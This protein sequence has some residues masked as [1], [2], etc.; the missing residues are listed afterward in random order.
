MYVSF[1]LILYIMYMYIIYMEFKKF[2]LL[3][4]SYL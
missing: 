3:K 4:D 1:W 2:F